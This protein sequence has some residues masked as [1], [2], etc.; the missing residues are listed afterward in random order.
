LSNIIYCIDISPLTARAARACFFVAG[1]FALSLFPRIAA[2]QISPA[3]FEE[4]SAVFQQPFEEKEEQALEHFRGMSDYP[5]HRLESLSAEELARMQLADRDD[6]ALNDPFLSLDLFRSLAGYY[7]ELPFDAES[8]I[9]KILANAPSGSRTKANAALLGALEFYAHSPLTRNDVEAGLARLNEIG[10]TNAAS[11][12]VQ[13]E[14]H[15]WK[16]EG[17]RALDEFAQAETEYSYAIAT[18]GNPRLAALTHFRMGELLEREH[19]HAAAD[20]NFYTASDIVESPLRLLSLLR[21]GAVQRA[22]RR[23]T[24]VLATMDKADSLFHSSQHIIRTSAR[25]LQYA[26]P[27]LEEMIMEVPEHDRILGTAHNVPIDSIPSQLISPFYRSEIEL[28]RGSALSELGKYAEATEILAHGEA[29]IDGATDSIKEP[30]FA[31][32]ALF[33]SDALRFERGWSLFQRANYQEAAAA[34]LELAVTDTGDR[35]YAILRRSAMPLREQGLYFDPFLNDSLTTATSG[36]TNAP[37]IDRSVLAKNTVDTSFFIYNDFPE[38]ARYYAGIAL[39]R[40]GMLNEAAD[41]LQVLSLNRSMLYSNN[42]IYQLALIRFVQHSY[43]AAALLEPVSEEKN[44]RGGYASFLLGELAYRRNDYE[45]AE[46][47]FLKA[48]ANLPLQDTAI[49]AT[50]HLERGLSLIPLNN[51]SDAADELSTYLDQSHEHLLGRTD[52]ALFWLGKAY[53]R[54]GEFDSAGVTF[55]HLLT[56]YSESGRREAAQYNYAWSLFEGNDFARS[57]AEFQRVITMDSISRYAYD[58]LARAGD[59]YYALHEMKRANKLYNLATDRPGFN[60]IRSTRALLMLGISRMK[61]DSERSAMN[62]FEYLI[63]KYPQ[64]DIVD[65]ASFDYALAAYA[66]H[67]TEPAETMVHSIVS[68][69]GHSALA[70]RALYVAAEERVR[71]GDEQGSIPY[72]EQVVNDYPRS[73][74]AGPALFGLQDALAGLDEIPRAITLADTFIARNPQNPINPSVLLREGVLQMKLEE[75]EQA[76]VTFRSFLNQYPLHPERPH[77]ELLEAESEV[78]S[79]D[80]EASLKQLDT[81]IARY[82][83]L[84]V[85]A[86]AYLDRAR[87]ERSRKNFDSSS[88]DFKRAYQERYYSFDAAP[89]SMYEYGEMLALRKK[90]DSAVHIFSDLSFRYPIEASISARGAMRA[91]ELL[92]GERKDDS[93]RT[94][95]ARVISA[96]P[97]D[98]LGGEATFRTGETYVAQGNWSKAAEAMVAGRRNFPLSADLKQRSLFELARAE[99]HLSKKAEAIRNLHELLAMRSLPEYEREAARS[100]LDTLE[101]PVKKKHKKGESE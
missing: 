67:L 13:P 30:S 50:A 89:E 45:R 60:P 33:I 3:P 63:R 10:S 34:F 38:R 9:D 52:E 66:I 43:E 96:H 72:Y 57:E 65:L 46:A 32:Q 79:N 40:A 5:P 83:T 85:A 17:Y 4:R 94:I 95:F 54:S 41:A 92:A 47:Y 44:I 35:H 71:R 37:T 11:G 23:F 39:A 93:A 27:L 19:R 82:D 36:T 51:W 31:E 42:A 53:F 15:F 61:I 62:A 22:E 77:A 78:A 69:Y 21:L 20:S 1:I 100:L 2:A 26:S 80:T 55:S 18:S 24:A 59:S 88:A 7:R 97:Q 91:G 64:S 29:L 58:A 73:S 86:G 81:V 28:L 14:I 101:S 75:P 87:I 8:Q 49:R 70:P 68:K 6:D 56:E 90:N 16:A 48:Y 99:V 84:D 76:L 12:N 98:V 25:D 74:E